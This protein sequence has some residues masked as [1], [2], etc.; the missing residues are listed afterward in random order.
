MFQK[1][2]VFLLQ[3]IA[4]ES[5]PHKLAI[6]CASAVYVSF[7][8]FMGFHTIMLIGAAWLFKTSIPLVVMLGYIINNPFTVVPIVMSGY[9]CGYWI[10][11]TKMGISILDANP[12]WMDMLNVFL[13]VKLG[14]PSI[15]LWAFIVG[16][17]VIGLLLAVASY[18]ILR[19]F[20]A[21][22]IRRKVIFD[23]G[24]ERKKE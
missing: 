15:S 19:A 6:A 7:S 5:S 23:G 2:R 12:D 20:F 9:T 16:A 11:H 1:I 14:L 18:I 10:I 22:W 8:P 13:Q 4:Y 21:Y 3:L 17:N 24:K